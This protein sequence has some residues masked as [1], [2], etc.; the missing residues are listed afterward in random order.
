MLSHADSVWLKALRC[1][2][3][4]LRCCW[5]KRGKL[6]ACSLQKAPHHLLRRRVCTVYNNCCVLTYMNHTRVSAGVAIAAVGKSTAST[7]EEASAGK[8]ACDVSWLKLLL[9][10]LGEAHEEV[11][12]PSV[13]PTNELLVNRSCVAAQH[14]VS[15]FV[16]HAWIC[17]PVRVPQKKQLR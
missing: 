15:H 2:S 6:S 9:S 7:W 4:A 1:L 11:I 5:L 10:D 12:G 16:R 3:T 8:P 14:N 13:P 17:A